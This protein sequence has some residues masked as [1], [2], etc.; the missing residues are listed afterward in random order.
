MTAASLWLPILVAGGVW[1]EFHSRAPW[2]AVVTLGFV[3]G[4][5]MW[6][7]LRHGRVWWLP[8]TRDPYLREAGSVGDAPGRLGNQAAQSPARAQPAPA[9]PWD[10]VDKSKWK[11]CGH[12]G[13]NI[14]VVADCDVN[15]DGTIRRLTTCTYVCPLCDH[16]HVG[17]PSAWPD[18]TEQVECHGCGA[19]LEGRDQCPKCAYPRGWALIG[20]RHR[21][22]KQPTFMPHLTDCCDLFTLECVRCEKVTSTP[23]IC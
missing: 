16:A 14:P 21:G 7:R 12:C 2:L 10:L 9:V 20:C 18:L 8:W 11:P 17:T 3:A 22:Q 6:W 13:R 23:C 19:N 4:W 1:L 5:V 15:A